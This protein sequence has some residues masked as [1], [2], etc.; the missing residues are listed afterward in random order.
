MGQGVLVGWVWLAVTTFGI[1]CAWRAWRYGRAP[2]HLRWDLYPVAHEA[3]PR[4]AYGGSRLEERDHWTKPHVRSLA[5]QLQVMLA[6][7][8]LLRGVWLHNRRV[9]S[10]SLPFHW[11]LYLLVATTGLLALA[12]LARFPGMLALARGL[13][14]GGGLLV[15]AGALRL[16]VLRTSDPGLKRYSSPLDRLNLGVFAL[17]GALSAAIAIVPGGMDGASRLLAGVLRLEPAVVPPLVVAHAALAGFV[18]IYLPFTRMV[19]FFSK[20]FLYHD[21]RWDDR[22][23]VAGSAMERRLHAALDYGV[24]WSADHVGS[25]RPWRQVAAG[26]PT[27]SSQGKRP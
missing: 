5:G 23:L 7:A 17:L 16:L 15:L 19:H 24:T 27:S 3:A 4:R 22:P 13:A 12:A 10:G 9:F 21:V 18:L 20:Y 26:A 11:G 1:G 14:I 8:L 2:V 25:G 6:E